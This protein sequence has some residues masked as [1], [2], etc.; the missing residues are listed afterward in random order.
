MKTPRRALFSMLTNKLSTGFWTGFL[1]GPISFFLSF[2]VFAFSYWAVR[3]FVW[4]AMYQQPYT[5]RVIAEGS[6][7][8]WSIQ[9]LWL[10]CSIVFGFVV[11]AVSG[12]S[13]GAVFSW[14]AALWITYCALGAI[15]GGFGPG[16]SV[17]LYLLVLLKT[18]IGAAIG[19]AW[20]NQKSN[21]SM[22]A[23]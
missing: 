1:L 6:G 15:F 2:V 12:R 22:R 10:F 19:F 13:V 20:W 16:A 21:F 8:W 23:E 9:I 14:F 4:A 3:P 17:W 11:T 5:S 7:E 18:P